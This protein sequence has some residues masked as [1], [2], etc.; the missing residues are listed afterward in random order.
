MNITELI[1]SDK[2]L[3]ELPFYIVYKT[4]YILWHMGLIKDT[5]KEENVG[6]V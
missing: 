6:A 4:I 1:K 3:N 2:D 5:E